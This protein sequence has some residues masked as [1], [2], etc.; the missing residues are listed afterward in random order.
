MAVGSVLVMVDWESRIVA[1]S[2][3]VL[4]TVVVLPLRR[5]SAMV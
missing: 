1:I 2:R 5:P 4:E 3:Q